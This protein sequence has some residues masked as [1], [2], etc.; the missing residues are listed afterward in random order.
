MMPFRRV[1]FLNAGYCTQW[2][3]LAGQRSRGLTRFHAVF[4]YLE[5]PVHG[6]ALID[7]G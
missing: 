5:H 3:Y 1:V 4:V 7:T 6:A 2:A